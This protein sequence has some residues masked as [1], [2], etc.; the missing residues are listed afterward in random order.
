MC[1]MK[2]S[3]C[4]VVWKKCGITSGDEMFVVVGE[5]FGMVAVTFGEYT[6]SGVFVG[7]KMFATGGCGTTNRFVCGVCALGDIFGDILG[8]LDGR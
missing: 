1:V 7:V 3:D 5:I 2:R 6:E 4:V 8:R